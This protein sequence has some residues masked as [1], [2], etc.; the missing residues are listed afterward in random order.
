VNVETFHLLQYLDEQAFRFNERKDDDA[1]R[2]VKAVS[3]VI[4]KGLKYAKLIRKIEK[5]G[6]Q[7]RGKR[8][9]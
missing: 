1:G 7:Q 5:D 4:G 9:K 8:R 3:G 6:W 2:F